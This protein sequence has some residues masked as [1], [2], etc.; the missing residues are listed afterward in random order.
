MK[1]SEIRAVLDKLRLVYSEGGAKSQAADCEKLSE[2]LKIYE[3]ELIEAFA[4]RVRDAFLLKNRKSTARPAA[5]CGLSVEDYAPALLAAG[6]D[7]EAFRT[8][9]SAVGSD[10]RVTKPILDNIAN[11][12]LNEVSGGNHLF[13]FKTKGLALDAIRNKF[14]ERAEAE[15]KDEIID[16]L[17]MRS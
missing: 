11:R 6:T 12:Y 7:D 8:L 13:R 16:R 14:V 4:Q 17:M 9:L 10:R 15:S 2:G 1:I 3:D 5:T